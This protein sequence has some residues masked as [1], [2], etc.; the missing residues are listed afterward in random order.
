MPKVILF[1]GNFKIN[2][3]FRE[4]QVRDIKDNHRFDEFNLTRN[5]LE[6]KCMLKELTEDDAFGDVR[7]IIDTYN[8]R[9]RLRGEVLGLL[10]NQTENKYTY[11][12]W[13]VKNN[14]LSREFT[15]CNITKKGKPRG[16]RIQRPRQLQRD[17]SEVVSIEPSSKKKLS[18]ESKDIFSNAP[19][20]KRPSPPPKKKLNMESKDIFSNAPEKKRPS[21]PPQKKLSFQHFVNA[22]EAAQKRDLE[23]PSLDDKDFNS[24]NENNYVSD[25]IVYAYIK[26]N[27][28]KRNDNRKI[29]VET[30]FFMECIENNLYGD[31]LEWDDF[32]NKGLKYYDYIIF[33]INFEYNNGKNKNK[34]QHWILCIIDIKKNTITIYDSE[35]RKYDKKVKQI[36]GFLVHSGAKKEF[37]VNYISKPRQPSGVDCGVFVAEY[38][39]RW[40]LNEPIDFTFNDIPQIR[41]DMKNALRPYLTDK[42]RKLLMQQVQQ[43]EQAQQ[44]KKTPIDYHKKEMEKILKNQEN[45]DC[46]D[47]NTNVYNK[48]IF[49]YLSLL[50]QNISPKEKETIGLTDDTFM[51]YITKSNTDAGVK[52]ASRNCIGLQGHDYKEYKYFIIPFSIN[53][54][55]SGN[56]GHAILAIID[57]SKHRILIYDS[58]NMKKINRYVNEVDAMRRFIKAQGI[59]ENYSLAIINEPQQRT[60]HDCGVFVME[61]A[62]NML[63]NIKDKF[64]QNDIKNIRKRIK[65][66]LTSRTL[67]FNK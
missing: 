17:S 32:K 18:M 67:S 36:N 57:N 6:C 41:I 65:Q 33:P 49:A 23:R 1:K 59:N 55:I 56:D 14:T 30:N 66:E 4:Q 60:E 61:F 38:A 50:Y 27:N 3:P 25:A 16:P 13:F 10:F 54:T 15:D 29:A 2:P 35:G 63:F 46:L 48:T 24:L 45:I 21:P 20:K 52:I 53:S 37:T 8:G 39:K 12:R 26:I 64:S 11:C 28:K 43:T 19:E 42:A 9:N 7:Y 31:I 47:G 22:S 34:G 44:P 62:R 5:S 40:L 51:Y 58:D